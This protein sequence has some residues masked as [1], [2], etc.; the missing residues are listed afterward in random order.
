MPKKGIKSLNHVNK[1]TD[2]NMAKRLNSISTNFSNIKQREN[3][4]IV[5]SFE[6]FDRKHKYFN[7]G[8]TCESWYLTLIDFFKDLCSINWTKVYNQ[9]R[10]KYQPHPVDNNANFFDDLVK[11]LGQKPE[12]TDLIQ[13]RINKS[14]GRVHGLKIGNRFYICWLDRHHNMYNSEGYGKAESHKHPKTCY[15]KLLD[16]NCCVKHELAVYEE[17]FDNYGDEVAASKT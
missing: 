1:I 11:L 7:L 6:L 4:N 8:K 12:Q 3:E 5:L 14:D 9:Y 2:A 13:L 17:I 10:K 15:D 16:E